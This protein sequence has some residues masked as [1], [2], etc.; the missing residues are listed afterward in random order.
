VVLDPFGRAGT[1]AKI[2]L[3]T[4]RRWIGFEINPEYIAIAHKRLR[5]AERQLWAS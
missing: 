1:T 4:G 3:L 5:K 2:A